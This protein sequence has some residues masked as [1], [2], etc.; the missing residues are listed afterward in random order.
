MKMMVI[1]NFEVKET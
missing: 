1:Q